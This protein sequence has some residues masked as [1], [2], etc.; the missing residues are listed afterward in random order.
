M[1][2][3][4][5]AEEVL[6]IY[7]IVP[8]SAA[9][10]TRSSG[11]LP[12]DYLLPVSDLDRKSG[13]M[14]MSTAAQISN[15]L[16]NFFP[17]S[18]SPIDSI[19]LLKVPYKPLKER[20][21]VRWEDPDGKIGG[22]RDGEGMFPHIYDDRQFKLSHEEVESVFELVSEAGEIGWEPALSRVTEKGWLV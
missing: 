7:K 1:V 16:K 15:T 4:G 11:Q 12:E 17:T 6:F 19:Y 21:L 8:S 18:S 2:A 10:P 14:H 9:V 22:P 20:G 3:M 5:N 13:F